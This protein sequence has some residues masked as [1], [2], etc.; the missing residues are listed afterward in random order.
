MRNPWLPPLAGLSQSLSFLL[1]C[2]SSVEVK[3]L[4]MRFRTLGFLRT[5]TYIHSWQGMGWELR[6]RCV[7]GRETIFEITLVCKPPTTS[8][9]YV[10]LS[11]SINRFTRSPTTSFSSVEVANFNSKT[12]SKSAAYGKSSSGVVTVPIVSPESRTREWKGRL[13]NNVWLCG[14]LHLASNW[15]NLKRGKTKSAFEIELAT[16]RPSCE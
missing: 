9:A 10:T 5:D 11:L 16:C 13:L 6:E 14:C 7:V 15:V 4:S 3:M 12:P 1:G 2:F 8:K